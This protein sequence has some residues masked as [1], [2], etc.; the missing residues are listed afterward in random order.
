[1]NSMNFQTFSNQLLSPSRF[2]DGWSKSETE[3]C[4]ESKNL[5]FE[6]LPEYLA[7]T[8]PRKTFSSSQIQ[9]GKKKKVFTIIRNIPQ[10]QGKRAEISKT[11][12]GNLKQSQRQHCILDKTH[13]QEIL[14]FVIHTFFNN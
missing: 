5:S 3:N 2:L 7:D 6:P 12:T 11:K 1:M 10:I 14:N 13:K 9:E 4:E 8:L